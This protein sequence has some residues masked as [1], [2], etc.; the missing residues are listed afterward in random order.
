LGNLY[1]L[2]ITALRTAAVS[3]GNRPMLVYPE[4]ILASVKSKTELV[5]SEISALVGLGF[6][7]IDYSIWVAVIKNLPEFRALFAIN[8]CRITTFYI[9]TSIPKSPLATI[10]P[11]E[12]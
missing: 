11:S 12:T 5:T 4:V 2:N 8:F 10:I 6:S 3:A 9:G 1:K 7:Y